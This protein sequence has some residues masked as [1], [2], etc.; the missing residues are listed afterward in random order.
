MKKPSATD[1]KYYNIMDGRGG[2]FNL[3]MYLKDMEAF[4]K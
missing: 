3:R 2:E 4:K 1:R